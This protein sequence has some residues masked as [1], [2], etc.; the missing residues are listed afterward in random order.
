MGRGR[1]GLGAFADYLWDSSVVVVSA[2]GRLV[3]C[4]ITFQLMAHVHLSELQTLYS[5][6]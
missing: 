2:P 6:S 5:A 4:G 1:L 3:A